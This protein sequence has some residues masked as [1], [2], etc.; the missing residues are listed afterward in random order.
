MPFEL[1]IS[2]VADTWRT[3]LYFENSSCDGFVLGANRKALQIFHVV[4]TLLQVCASMHM[5]VKR[6][7]RRGK[8]HNNLIIVK[9]T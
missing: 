3:E 8:W 1:L 6:W 7:E 2:G 4:T 9:L 5:K